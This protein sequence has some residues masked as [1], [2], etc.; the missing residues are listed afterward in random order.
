MLYAAS[1]IVVKGTELKDTETLRH[2]DMGHRR[3]PK[4]RSFTCLAS[5]NELDSSVG[6]LEFWPAE[7]PLYAEQR[8]RN[9]PAHVHKYRPGD[10]NVLQQ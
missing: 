7:S 5:L 1:F 3:V 9:A 4:G 10:G 2:A 6:G 8:V